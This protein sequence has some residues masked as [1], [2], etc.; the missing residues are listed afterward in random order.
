MFIQVLSVAFVVVHKI[1]RLGHLSTK[2][3]SFG[4]CVRN[5]N[6]FEAKEL[7]L[8]ASMEKQRRNGCFNEEDE[9]GCLNRWY[10][11]ILD[12]PNANIEGDV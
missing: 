12:L 10:R 6:C 11:K 7:D 4:V 2:Y 8:C 3:L 9:Q 5:N 1:S